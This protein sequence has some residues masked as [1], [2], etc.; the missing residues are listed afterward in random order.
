MKTNGLIN[1]VM[2]IL[3]MVIGA[4]FI[5]MYD[6]AFNSEFIFAFKKLSIPIFIISQALF[7]IDYY[8]SKQKYP[9]IKYIA[10]SLAFYLVVLL[11]SGGYVAGYNAMVGKQQHLDV[12]GVIKN[13]FTT[14]GKYESYY[15][16]TFANEL[17]TNIELSVTKNEFD[18]LMVGDE[19]RTSLTKGSLGIYYK[20]GCYNYLCENMVIFLS[21][22]S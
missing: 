20:I 12:S 3:Y 21:C 13:K 1:N 14:S 15:I 8:Q 5:V 7:Y 11:C 2:L 4:A 18:N 16:E 9:T 17:N 19:Y 6:C 22:E 10:I